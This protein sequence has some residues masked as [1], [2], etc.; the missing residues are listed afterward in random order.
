MPP[1]AVGRGIVTRPEKSHVG[2]MAPFVIRWPMK[3]TLRPTLCVRVG[4]ERRVHSAHRWARARPVRSHRLIF[5][6]AIILLSFRAR[7]M[8]ILTRPT[9][10]FAL[11]FGRFAAGSRHHGVLRHQKDGGVAILLRRHLLPL[12]VVVVVSCRDVRQRPS[13]GV[14]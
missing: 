5:L 14:D 11:V 6:M 12:V 3:S 10:G 9:F 4:N 7:K 1:H 2:Q 13:T 8:K